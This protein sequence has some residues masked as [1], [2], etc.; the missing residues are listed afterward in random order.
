MA[1]TRGFLKLYIQKYRI[2]SKVPSIISNNKLPRAYRD[3][4]WTLYHR[5][6]QELH[7]VF[8]WS[9]RWYTFRWLCCRT[10][11]YARSWIWLS[12]HQSLRLGDAPFHRIATLSV[13]F[14]LNHV[15]SCDL[16]NFV[17]SNNKVTEIGSVCFW[18]IARWKRTMYSRNAFVEQ[19]ECCKIRG[20]VNGSVIH[21]HRKW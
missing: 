21:K 20:F 18:F 9:L 7:Y 14:C 4:F 13:L 12:Y 16:S 15:L 17:E 6:L 11:F 5:Q 8:P 19:F 2:V 10:Y 3:A 1:S